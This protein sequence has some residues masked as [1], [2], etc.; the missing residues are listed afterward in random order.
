M[1]VTDDKSELEERLGR[2]ELIT[3]VLA[4]SPSLEPDRSVLA[5]LKKALRWDR[6]NPLNDPELYAL[7]RTILNE[8]RP[9]EYGF[10]EDGTANNAAGF[11]EPPYRSVQ[12]ALLSRQTLRLDDRITELQNKQ[13]ETSREIHSWLTVQS[14]GLDTSDIPLTRFIPLKVYLSETENVSVTEVAAALSSLVE[15]V[16]F[17]VS[18]EFP[19]IK[20]SWYQKWFARTKDVAT[21]D[22]VKERLAKVERALEIKGLALPQAEADEKLASAVEKLSK[23]TEH[24]PST[25]MQVGSILFVKVT[26]DDAPAIHVRTLTAVEMIQLEN[27][28]D[29]LSSP[30]DILQKLASLCSRPSV[31]GADSDQN[32]LSLSY[33]GIDSIKKYIETGKGELPTVGLKG[34]KEEDWRILGGILASKPG[35][36]DDDTTTPLLGSPKPEKNS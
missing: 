20:G 25:A 36:S 29:L 11:E 21:S 10:E 17:E 1:A 24:V 31:I 15:A 5:R 26:K 30:R 34:L 22:A 16:G 9:S 2:L 7:A 28:P 19:G 27:N 35:G 14:M 18:D 4:A 8:R 3:A 13:L 33:G 32:T 12:D 6:P 23:A